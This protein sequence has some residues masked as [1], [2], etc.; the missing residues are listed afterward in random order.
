MHLIF[1]VHLPHENILIVSISQ[2]TICTLYYNIRVHR[3][4]SV[5]TNIAKNLT[6]GR[7]IFIFFVFLFRYFICKKWR[8]RIYNCCMTTRLLILAFPLIAIPACAPELSNTIAWHTHQNCSPGKWSRVLA[9]SIASTGKFD[10]ECSR[11]RLRVPECLFAT[12]NE[13]YRV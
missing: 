13:Y 9:S 12:S 4:V 7:S 6:G 10:C 3:K 1:I 11:V 5:L 2:I 8:R